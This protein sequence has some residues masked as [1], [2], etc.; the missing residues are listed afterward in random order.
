MEQGSRC[1]FNPANNYF[2][3][4]CSKEHCVSPIVSRVESRKTLAFACDT[5]LGCRVN[6]I[7]N[8][9]P[10]RYLPVASGRQM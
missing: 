9:R 2:L 5:D 4:A 8:C 1:M 3:N 7:W 10:A 6:V